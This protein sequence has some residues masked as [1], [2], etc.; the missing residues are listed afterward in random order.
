MNKRVVVTAAIAGVVLLG[1]CASHS[2]PPLVASTGSSAAPIGG[3]GTRL[4]P[5]VDN[6]LPASVVGKHPCDSALT[7]AQ[8]T[9][10][11][12]EVPPA[13]HTDQTAG[14]QCQWQKQSNG[15]TIAV[16]WL[17][18]F[19]DGLN[20]VYL[21]Q[22]EDAYFQPLRFEGYPAVVYDITDKTPDT[23]CAISVG[24]TDRAV[25]DVGL[26]LGSERVGK[27]NPCDGAKTIAKM[28]LDNVK[29]A[30]R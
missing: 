22:R 7:D 21:N 5:K 25:I 14:P 2:Q 15:A 26:T 16:A 30:A 18:G 23:N 27:Q 9:N 11:L 20:Q 29:A 24:I 13:F 3:S 6:P 28:V 1:G 10:L 4:A 19:T 17:T 12:G 8:L